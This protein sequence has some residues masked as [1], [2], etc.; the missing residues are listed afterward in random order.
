MKILKTFL[1]ICIL[2]FL[3]DTA[4]AKNYYF[5]STGSDS[6]GCTIGS[7]CKSPQKAAAIATLPGDSLLF[8]CGGTYYI[9]LNFTHSGTASQPIVISSYGT[10]AQPIFTVAPT[11]GWTGPNTLG[12]YTKAVKNHPGTI[13]FYEDGLPLIPEASSSALADGMW[14]GD[15]SYLYYKP[16]TGTPTSH[17]LS[18]ANLGAE[19]GYIPAIDLSGCSYVTVNNINFTAVGIGVKTFEVSAG[20]IG[21]VVQNCNFNYCQRAIFI[22]PGPNNNTGMVIQK[23]YFYRCQ[24]GISMY[25]WTAEGTN[26]GSTAG[27]NQNCT[28]SNNEFSQIGTIDG[29]KHWNVG[30]DFEGIGLNNFM[31]GTI[32]N[33]YI[34]DGF[35]IGLSWYNITTR[36]SSN[37]KIFG[38]TFSNTKKG[39]MTF[40]GDQV[41]TIYNYAYNNNWFYQN[42]ILTGCVYSGVFGGSVVFYQGANTT[43]Q[44]Y[45]VNNTLSGNQNIVYFPLAS[46]PYFTI[47]NNIYYNTGQ[48]GFM[49]WNW[50]AKPNTLVMDYNVYYGPTTNM[51][52]SNSWVFVY[53]RPITFVRNLGMELHSMF[54]N[55]MFNNTSTNDYHLQNASPA[56]HAG[57]NVGL[58]F[59]GTAPDCGA[60]PFTTTTS[61]SSSTSTTTTTPATHVKPANPSKQSGTPAVY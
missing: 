42:T 4:F 46:E 9:P 1:P 54:T 47:E 44:N 45:F 24:C 37:N 28:I 27:T 21:L 50:T 55:P 2:C 10:G 18:F 48:Y 53:G 14:Y 25:T 51:A 23:N 32:S 59:T 58:P 12:V 13:V 11:T 7:P 34:H 19:P 29:T 39:A 33:N 36:E 43:A 15:G 20:T 41:G 56:I 40:V 30:T 16:V 22:M 61:S 52:A 31:N 8:Q 35:Q 6:N 38:N 57:T 17:V 5:S 3:F 49:N 26:T 60:Y